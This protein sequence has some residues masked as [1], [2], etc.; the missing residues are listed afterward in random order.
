[1]P[2]DETIKVQIH[3]LTNRSRECRPI[4]NAES[5]ETAHSGKLANAA[6]PTK[7][8]ARPRCG[9]RSKVEH[10]VGDNQRSRGPMKK[11]VLSNLG[12]S[13]EWQNFQLAAPVRWWCA[14]GNGSSLDRREAVRHQIR[15]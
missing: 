6:S 11:H 8:V 10:K 5:E 3:Q 12:H 2:D 1:M 4:A 7:E 9:G 14:Q 15:N 13:F